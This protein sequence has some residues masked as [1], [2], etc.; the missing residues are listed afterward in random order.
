MKRSEEEITC[1]WEKTEKIFKFTEEEEE[2][3]RQEMAIIQAM[4]DARNEK[5]MTQAELSKKSGVSQPVIARMEKGVN[6][7]QLNTLIKILNALG[8]K[9]KI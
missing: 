7:P 4:I 5:E 3:I 8:R 2:E 9:I 1:D 6:S